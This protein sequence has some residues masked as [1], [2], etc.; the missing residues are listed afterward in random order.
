MRETPK[1]DS[2]NVSGPLPQAWASAP[3]TGDLKE[4][5]TK[6]AIKYWANFAIGAYFS[7]KSP[8]EYNFTPSKTDLLFP[9]RSKADF[10]D[11]H[12]A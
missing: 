3:E 8:G 12:P 11:P 6:V 4:I 1:L 9:T 10:V 2:A 7:G 5:S